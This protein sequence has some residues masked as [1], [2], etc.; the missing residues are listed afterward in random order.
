MTEEL[1]DLL[2]GNPEEDDKTPAGFEDSEAGR[3]G[4][5]VDPD[6]FEAKDP[7][8][9]ESKDAEATPVEE[10]EKPAEE[11]K[12]R[13]KTDTVPYGRFERIVSERNDAVAAQHKSSEQLAEIIKAQQEFLARQ[14]QLPVP[15]P[16]EDPEAYLASVEARAEAAEVKNQELEASGGKAEQA[17]KESVELESFATQQES[18]LAAENPHYYEAVQFGIK[19]AVQRYEYQG[20]SP[21]SAAALVHGEVSAMAAHMKKTGGNF[22][23]WSL[24]KSVEFGFKPDENAE[25]KSEPDAAEDKK[26]ELTKAADKKAEVQE[27]NKSV[28]SAGAGSVTGLQ[29]M[30][31]DDMSDEDF[32]KFK[33]RLFHENNPLR[34]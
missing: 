31:V 20:H 26:K 1:A 11:P 33:A 9:K 21:V 13:A 32:Q 2:D 23:K 15:D 30:D 19:A 24:A 27:A 28:A 22:A 14:N 29:D 8:D 7:P 18:D 25:V 6:D 34:A 17:Q 5:G 3:G 4:D 12:E 10:E 16:D